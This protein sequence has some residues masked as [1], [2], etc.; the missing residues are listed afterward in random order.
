MFVI[1]AS[2]CKMKKKFKGLALI[3]VT[4]FSAIAMVTASLAWFLEMVPYSLEEANIKG[5]TGGAYFAYGNGSQNSPYG[6]ATSRHLYNLAWMQYLG[7]FDDKQYYFELANNVDMSGYY[8][9]P[10]GTIEHPFLGEFNG[11]NYTVS[12]L[13]VTNNYSDFTGYSQ[14]PQEVTSSNF[15][16]PEIVGF[17]GVVGLLPDSE[18]TYTYNSAINNFT[19]TTLN[20]ISI[21]T[22]GSGSNNLLLA[23]LAAGYSS[24]ILQGIKVDG[25]STLNV[26]GQKHADFTNNITD[27]GLVGYTTHESSTGTYSQDLSEYYN[28]DP[29]GDGQDWGG[30]VLMDEMYNRLYSIA[31]SATQNSNYVFERNK[32]TTT[33]TGAVSYTNAKTGNAYTYRSQKIGSFV[34]NTAEDSTNTPQASWLYLTG[35][36]RIHQINRT[37]TYYSDWAIS[38]DGQYLGVNSSGQIVNSPIGWKLTNNKL[39]CKVGSTTYY[40]N[41]DC[42]AVTTTSDTWTKS[43]NQF[44]YESGNWIKIKHYLY[45]GGLFSSSWD[46]SLTSKDL[47]LSTSVSNDSSGG[48]DY[49]DYSGNEV[50]YFPL[51]TED[52]NNNAARKNTGYVIGGSEDK[53]SKYYPKKSGDIR[54]SKYGTA[55]IDSSYDSGSLTNVYTINASGNR[56]DITNNHSSYEKYE[57]SRTDLLSMISGGNIYGLHFMSA[58]ININNL[59]TA[60]YTLINGVTRSNYKMPASSI[61]FNLKQKGYINFFAGTY[62]KT[63]TSS[64]DVWNDSFFSLHKIERN[65]SNEITAIK[66]IKEIYKS[67][68]VKKDHIYKYTDNS[69]SATITSDYSLAF[70]TSRI[71]KQSNGLTHNAVYYFEIPM[72][73]G[74]FALGSVSGGTGAYLMYLDIGANGDAM[75]SVQAYS[76]TTKRTKNSYPNGVDFAPVTTGNNGGETMCI[77]IASGKTG[78]ITFGVTSG[79]INITSTANLSSYSYKGS[80]YVDG[81]PTSGKFNVSGTSP[82]NM[83][84]PPA[85]GTRI[86]TINVLTVYGDSFVVRITDLLTNSSGSFNESESV[87][88]VSENGGAFVTRNRS[89]VINVSGQIDLDLF[90]SLPKAATL[91]RS[92]GTGDF[93]TTYD[94][95]NCNYWNKIVDVDIEKNGTTISIAVTSGY[96]FKIGGVTKANGSTY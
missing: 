11:N 61:D 91:T 45:Y 32:I 57:D 20:S 54:V 6:I 55:S 50:T 51:I 1:G 67:S 74:E 26:N 35:G 47:T 40:L 62:Y 42:N 70:A 21:K 69:T 59:V 78:S 52:G 31:G 72:N 84:L 25:N 75:D 46:T 88:E 89:Y 44:Y 96:T 43:G 23:G 56:Q 94:I 68:N 65:T 5:N 14:S 28:G 2:D 80:K 4:A 15:V 24:G 73:A 10:I 60:D 16:I 38:Y 64:G 13:T 87:Y 53:S 83:V 77:E 58:N 48:A 27:Y 49:M 90:R 39:N 63:E 66:E 85:G 12:G 37:I 18:T 34:F 7:L 33:N 36:K 8:L 22:D 93:I 19:D 95:D 92:T 86:L 9:P 71:K 17:F 82:G 76:I 3:S 41:H 30:S 29:E 81:T 79:N